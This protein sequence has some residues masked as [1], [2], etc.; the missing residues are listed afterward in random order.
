MCD[1]FDCR[2]CKLEDRLTDIAMGT[3]RVYTK[4][5]LP[6]SDS[7]LEYNRAIHL[8]LMSSS[9]SRMGSSPYYD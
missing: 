1:T 3:K 2:D 5:T 8:N 4:S 6:P 7:P 9:R